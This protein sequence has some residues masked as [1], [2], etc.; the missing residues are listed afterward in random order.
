MSRQTRRSLLAGAAVL[1]G[2]AGC[3]DALRSRG[4]PSG[5]GTPTPLPDRTVSLPDGPKDVPAH[6]EALTEDAVREFALLFE[7]RY[8]YNELWQS[9]DSTVSLSCQVLATESVADH[10]AVTVRSEGSAE[11]AAADGTPDRDEWSARVVT[12]R[13][14]EDS[15]IRESAGAT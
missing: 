12:Y 2:G 15:V 11:T 1:A 13:V 9:A 10:V 14:D 3:V 8:A 6:P 7:Y 5:D 4:A